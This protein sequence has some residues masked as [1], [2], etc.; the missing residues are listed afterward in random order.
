LNNLLTAAYQYIS[1]G[2]C[3][4]A[5]GEEKSAF[6]KWKEYEERIITKDEVT[7]HFNHPL[8]RSLAIVCGK[9]SGNLEVVDIDCKYDLTGTLFEDYMQCIKDND[10]DLYSRLMVIQTVSGGYH[11]YYRCSAIEDN[12]KLAR[13]PTTD[14]EKQK[15]YDKN[16]A[17]EIGKGVSP[18][19][20]E[21]VA[22]KGAKKDEFRVLIETRGLR[23]Y[24]VAPPSTGYSVVSGSSIPNITPAEREILFELAKSFNQVIDPPVPIKQKTYNRKEF[25]LSPFED[26]NKKADVV[27]LLKAHS[28]TVIRDTNE[29]VILRRPGKDK[30]T[31]G[32]YLKE[33]QWFSVFTTSSIFE[34]QKAYLPY[35]VY[36]MLEC[37]GD[38]KLA[39]QKLLDAGYGEKR[40]R[41]DEKLERELYR[42]KQNG[43]SRDELVGYL[44]KDKKKSTAEAQQ[45]VDHLTNAW[46]EQICT[47]WDIDSK[48]NATLNR[49]KFN[50]FLYEVGGFSLYYYRMD[51][52]IFKVVQCR[53][54][55]VREV[56]TEHMKKFVLDYVESL[57]EA[58]DGGITPDDL[59]ELI[60]K[61]ASNYF[62]S[63][64]L[65][66][67]QRSNF[68]FLRD[69]KEEAF[70]P[71]LNGVV[72]VSREE[73][74]LL[75]YAAIKKVIWL[76]QVNQADIQLIPEVDP[77]LVEYYNFI[78]CISNMDN[79]RRTYAMTLIGYL[80]H[81]YKDPTRP[82][83]VVLAE[84]TE[85]ESDGGGTGKGIFVKALT[86][87]VSTIRIDGKNFKADKNFA[88]QRVGPDTK[89]LSIEDVRKNVDFEGFY[90]TITEGITVEK[91]NKDELF[92]PYQD[93][94]KIIFT[95]NYTI[96]NT[97]NHARR[98]QKVM[99]FT[100]FFRP[101]HTPE[102]HFR[103]KLFD[104][105]DA[106]E[107]NRF[108]N[109]MF[110]CTSVYLENGVLEQ[111]NSE[112]IKRKQI[113]LGYGDEF[114]EWFDDYRSNGCG[115][116]KSIGDLHKDFCHENEM[117]DKD[118]S[119]KRFKHGLIKAT[120]VFEMKLEN[121]KNRQLNN[122]REVRVVADG[123]DKKE[124]NQ[125]GIPF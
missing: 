59:S 42:K 26:Y 28:W 89:L 116:W 104:D 2:I 67:L 53:D 95:T 107:W 48:G 78:D 17:I 81:Q 93:S 52:I 45:I 35:A 72:C 114:M 90:P 117:S 27:D 84:E 86:Y 46:G 19:E 11:L 15:T 4:I 32:N 71:F 50:N 91:K 101:G 68:D 57:P 115:D 87:L 55:F 98:R 76:T 54:G 73:I 24:V 41:Y 37:D 111:V 21:I 102:D 64:N 66:F 96:P 20:A 13:R 105:W 92:I 8:A 113:R 3:V 60:M 56:S 124:D 112:S 69:T 29:R 22:R 18:E 82:F 99:E 94:P 100:N 12:I 97:G 61:G 110:A 70:F 65:E 5:T 9:A 109:F 63:C 38:F 122:R 58:F 10:E 51:S 74:R 125:S 119:I 39:A 34:A 40:T 16:Y 118:Y 25:G 121:R 108:Y 44:E 7:Q 33:K 23:G 47:F 106:D 49:T 36:T 43:A 123:A 1:N 79:N 120:D 85:K 6:F 14:Q 62:S 103:H 77:G 80:L 31:S 88:F 75:S 30:G 83:A